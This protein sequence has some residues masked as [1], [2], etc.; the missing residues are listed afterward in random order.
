[1]HLQI[2]LVDLG[3]IGVRFLFHFQDTLVIDLVFECLE[4]A[5]DFF[6]KPERVSGTKLANVKNRFYEVGQF[7]GIKR[8]LCKDLWIS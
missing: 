4:C 5:V 1:M 3:G 6:F 2:Q 7:V 8:T